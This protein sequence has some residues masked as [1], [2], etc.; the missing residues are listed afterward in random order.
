MATCRNIV[1][2]LQHSFAHIRCP[3]NSKKKSV[4][5]FNRH[6]INNNNK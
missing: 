2:A 3:Q 1:N 6:N 4:E 5:I